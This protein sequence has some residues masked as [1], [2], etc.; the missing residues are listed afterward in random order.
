MRKRKENITPKQRQEQRAVAFFPHG[1]EISNLL[2][3]DTD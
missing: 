1:K 2:K 3:F